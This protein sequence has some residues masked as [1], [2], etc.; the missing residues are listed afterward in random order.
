MQPPVDSLR[1]P[2]FARALRALNDADVPCFIAGAFA[3]HFY[4]GIWRCTK[5]LDIFC[6]PNS[7]ERALA[8]LGRAGF[9]THVEE[10]HWLGKA[11]CGDVLVDV[12]WAGGNWATFI[13]ETWLR[14]SRPALLLDE[15]VRYGAP[16]DIILSKAY[17]AGRERF[18]GT[19]IAHLVHARG[20]EF[21]W[22]AFVERFGH[23]WP[24]LLHY[25]VLYRFVYPQDREVVPARVIRELASRIGTDAETQ[26][27]LAFRGP[28]LDR[29]G[30]LVDLAA[31]GRADP[32]EILAARAGLPVANVVKRRQ[33]DQ[34]ALDSGRVYRQERED[35]GELPGDA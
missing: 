8:A 15:T 30:Y 12:I 5:D 4:T 1:Q 7:A 35:K 11:Y 14:N 33:L 19:D 29:Y 25:L 17:V 20:R 2:I 3:L 26:D 16:E 24:L 27:G 32:R 22:T 21:D 23:H 6:M 10:E 34:E 28:L 9:L 18:D 31:Q 13:D